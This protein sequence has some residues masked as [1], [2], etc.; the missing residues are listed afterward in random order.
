MNLKIVN[1]HVFRLI[2]DEPNLASQCLRLLRIIGKRDWK[3]KYGQDLIGMI[4]FVEPPREGICYIADNWINL[5]NTKGFGTTQRS[6]RWEIRKWVKK[7]PKYIFATRL[8]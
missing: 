3:E 2:I 5:G 1:N 7:T 6:N 8:S 4:T